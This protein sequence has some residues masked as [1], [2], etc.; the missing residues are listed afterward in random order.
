MRD[1]VPRLLMAAGL[2]AVLC[3]SELLGAAVVVSNADPGAASVARAMLAGRLKMAEDRITVMEATPVDWPDASLGCPE[4]GK[5]YAQMITSGHRVRLSAEGKTYEVHVAGSRAVMCDQGRTASPSAPAPS[6][7]PAHPPRATHA[8]AA[9]RVSR[10]ARQDLADALKIPVTSVKV[11]SVRPT[12][13]P[14]Q[15][16]GCPGTAPAPP[17]AT[18]G[19][20]LELTARGKR[21]R[22]HADLE[23]V[24]RCD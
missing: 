8:A 15:R 2:A 22:Y 7:A 17:Q 4:P 18:S 19:F 10:A 23:R 5:M 6:A 3:G 20:L 11:T 14:D 1:C 13:W 16:L 21:Y 24:V 12:S 9:A